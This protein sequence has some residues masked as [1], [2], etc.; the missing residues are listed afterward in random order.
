MAKIYAK[1]V[2]NYFS[3]QNN[4]NTSIYTVSLSVTVN[5]DVS[6]H[7]Q[8]NTPIAHNNDLKVLSEGVRNLLGEILQ[9]ELTFQ[10][11][12]TH[13]PEAFKKF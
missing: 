10:S 2:H 7:G 13:T 3:K 1:V 9:S 12:Y 8:Q 6:L 11:D 5:Y 4:P